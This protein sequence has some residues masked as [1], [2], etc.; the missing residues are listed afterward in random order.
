MGGSA[1]GDTGR[2]SRYILLTA[3]SLAAV[4][5]GVSVILNYFSLSNLIN[6]NYFAYLRSLA[7]IIVL[8][9]VL[10]IIR[11][12]ILSYSVPG[13][14]SAA[15]ALN[16]VVSTTF[17]FAMGVVFLS[18][19]G[20]SSEAAIISGGIMAAVVGLA[21]STIISGALSG[22]YFNLVHPYQK[23]DYVT[24]RI[25][26]SGN[27]MGTLIPVLYPKYLSLDRMEDSFFTGFVNDISTYFTSL[28]LDDGRTVKIPNQDI[29]TG[30]IISAGKD[31]VKK[32]RAEVSKAIDFAD[33][34]ARV[35]HIMEE[36]VMNNVSMEIYIDEATL[37]T[38]L[39]S[40]VVKIYDI[41]MGDSRPAD[42]AGAITSMKTPG[43]SFLE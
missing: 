3:V 18:T 17:Y 23:G 13:K 41:T 16:I 38:Y 7:V 30:V 36:A 28:E 10:R 6:S 39:V 11:R 15:S 35:E 34:K 4:Y 22:I 27:P 24:I 32:I 8:Y 5:V 43:I 1:S 2:F 40:I 31:M 33:L 37:N 12:G 19:A 29:V 20:I 26:I 25:M 42:L 14:R 21:G 9:I